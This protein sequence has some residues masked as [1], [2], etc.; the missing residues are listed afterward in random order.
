MRIPGGQR[1]L[2]LIRRVM[3]AAVPILRGLIGA[4]GCI[5]CDFC[6]DSEESALWFQPYTDTGRARNHFPLSSRE[7]LTRELLTQWPKGIKII[8]G[9]SGSRSIYEELRHGNPLKSSIPLCVLLQTYSINLYFCAGI[10]IQS[11]Q[12]CLRAAFQQF[13]TLSNNTILLT[14]RRMHVGM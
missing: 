8:P 12:G 13:W 3:R 9:P 5:I 10:L 4:A 7:N 6:F 11:Y 1:Y 2:D 14:G